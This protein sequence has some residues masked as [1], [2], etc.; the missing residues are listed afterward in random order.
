MRT[1]FLLAIVIAACGGAPPAVDEREAR[2]PCDPISTE[3]PAEVPPAQS[4]AATCG[5]G[6]VEDHAVAC[7][8]RCHG[9]CDREITCAVECNHA[10]EACDLADVR[11]ETC[12]SRGFASGALACRAGCAALD[13]SECDA[14]A[15]AAC[16]TIDLGALAPSEDDLRLVALG[17]AVRAFWT[18]EVDDE[19]HL[20]TA[21]VEPGPALSPPI[22]L[23]IEVARE[24]V[25]SSSAWI[26]L[27]ELNGAIV[28]RTI[29]A[30]GRI[31][32]APAGIA[33]D[34]GTYRMLAVPARDGAL[35]TAG[36]LG[37]N[38][39]PVVLVDRRGTVVPLPARGAVHAIGARDR[40]AIV[41]VGE[42]PA[43]VQ[44][45][46]A[47]SLA[48]DARPG[49]R[50][51]T[52]IHVAESCAGGAWC[53]GGAALLRDGSIGVPTAGAAPLDPPALTIAVGGVTRVAFAEDADTIDGSRAPRSQVVIDRSPFAPAVPTEHVVRAGD[54][55]AAR[56]DPDGEGPEAPRVLVASLR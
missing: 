41:P 33:P 47:E 10:R 3:R 22:D 34:V 26:T 56:F 44:L 23:G 51:A 38:L 40:M 37:S 24:I 30:R 35:I 36:E 17:R 19:P 29:D 1:C 28:T 11:G 12:T 53:Y 21:L 6:R 31:A 42:G 4:I 27:G 18:A 2:M 45:A 55:I 52:W 39:V 20:V 14:C 54:V 15:T 50:L 7:V 16:R 49:D 43:T 32:T 5:N 48:I 13:L 8:E 25:A 9:G 46:G